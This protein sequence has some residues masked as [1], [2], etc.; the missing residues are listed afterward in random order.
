MKNIHHPGRSRFRA[1]ILPSAQIVQTQKLESKLQKSA[2]TGMLDGRYFCNTY[3]ITSSSS[4]GLYPTAG[5]E[6]TKVPSSRPHGAA[7]DLP[8]MGRK[9]GRRAAWQ[10]PAEARRPIEY[11]RRAGRRDRQA[12]SARKRQPNRLLRRPSA[13]RPPADGRYCLTVKDVYHRTAHA[14][15]RSP[16]RLYAAARARQRSARRAFAASAWWC[17][18]AGQRTRSARL[19]AG[20]C[21]RAR[22]TFRAGRR[23]DG[24]SPADRP[25]G[26]C[27]LNQEEHVQIVD[28]VQKSKT[29]LLMDFVAARS[30]GCGVITAMATHDAVLRRDGGRV[31]CRDETSTTACSPP[32]RPAVVVDHAFF[33]QRGC[34]EYLRTR[35]PVVKDRPASSAGRLERFHMRRVI[36]RQYRT[37]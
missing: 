35:A 19:T 25:P 14:G 3:A 29:G 9:E 17:R 21:P 6:Y 18:S 13:G 7:S 31:L 5:L 22:C 26:R 10:V 20:N 12:T 11:G 23:K 30:A 8:G 2:I 4:D 32:A 28:N 37:L 33:M 15:A 1:A 36:N 16:A 27:F 24:R 34:F